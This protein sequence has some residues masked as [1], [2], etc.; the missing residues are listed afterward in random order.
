MYMYNANHVVHVYILMCTDIQLGVCA[1][2]WSLACRSSKTFESLTHQYELKE[3]SLVNLEELLV[4]RFNVVCPLIFILFVL[5]SR[6]V[7]L[8]VGGPVYHLVMGGG[9]EGG[10]CKRARPKKYDIIGKGISRAAEWHKFELC[11]TFQ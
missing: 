2:C 11:S 1:E 7:V 5:R 3:C 4:P 10:R 6:W 8:V 9:G